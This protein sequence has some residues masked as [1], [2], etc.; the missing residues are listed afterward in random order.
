MTVK[1]LAKVLMATTLLYSVVES[2]SAWGS[3]TKLR[4]PHARQTPS[5]RNRASRGRDSKPSARQGHRKHISPITEGPATDT[6]ALAADATVGQPAPTP[7]EQPQSSAQDGEPL[8]LDGLK[9]WKRHEWAQARDNFSLALQRGL[10]PSDSSL[11]TTYLTLSTQ[12]QA[13]F[14]DPWMYDVQ[15]GVG[16]G[17]DTNVGITGQIG[18]SEVDLATGAGR[19]SP[20]GFAGLSLWGGR[21]LPSRGLIHGSYSLS[22]IAYTEAGT[23]FFSSQDH[24]ASLGLRLRPAE[25]FRISFAANGELS[26]AGL[27]SGVLPLLA[28]AGGRVELALIEN[29]VFSTK[30]GGGA[31]QR[32]ALDSDYSYLGGPRLEA[33]LAED[34]ESGGFYTTVGFRLRE[35]RMG[36]RD[37]SLGQYDN[38]PVCASCEVT[39]RAQYAY[40]SLGAFFRLSSPRKRRVRAIIRARAEDRPYLH[41]VSLQ[42]RA[43]GNDGSFDAR[44]RHDQR[45]TA[46]TELVLRLWHPVELAVSYDFIASRSNVAAHDF[47]R[48]IQADVICHPYDYENRNFNKHMFTLE[49]RAHWQ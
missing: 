38:T 5:T 4:G 49:L 42:G 30:L 14:A 10:S 18:R 21:L 37:G 24:A 8:L 13:V 9:Q 33:Q 46:G 6:D 34:I 23:D 3:G 20:F 39:Y 11:A 29:D 41:E 28:L 32:F 48:C 2:P 12:M 1:L 36:S 22:Q 44:K 7:T 40:R 15:V 25:H 31:D 19:A 35:E 27:Q 26:M 43:N 16:G 47:D 17:L 45:V